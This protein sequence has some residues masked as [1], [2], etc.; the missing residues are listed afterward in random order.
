MAARGGG[1]GFFI[2]PPPAPLALPVF[3]PFARRRGAGRCPCT[4]AGCPPSRA[5]GGVPGGALCHAVLG[6]CR[7][8][9]RPLPPPPLSIPCPLP[10]TVLRSYSPPWSGEGGSAA[11]AFHCLV[12][13]GGLGPPLWGLHTRG[14]WVR[15]SPRP[16]P[17]VGPVGVGARGSRRA[18]SPA[19]RDHLGGDDTSPP[20]LVPS[21]APPTSAGGVL[22]G[23]ARPLG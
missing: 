6:T 13:G 21:G 17:D 3:S 11:A 14:G 22:G 15:I 23:A 12:G 18:P 16:P 7:G 10:K 19:L 4:G 20:P 8:G 9:A 1:T 5:E 2:R